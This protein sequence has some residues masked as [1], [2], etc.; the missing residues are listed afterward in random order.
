MKSINENIKPTFL[1][2]VDMMLNDTINCINIDP[3]IAS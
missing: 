3:N 2:N 1:Q